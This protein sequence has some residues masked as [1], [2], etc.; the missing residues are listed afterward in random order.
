MTGTSQRT[1]QVGATF[2]PY[3]PADLNACLALFDSNCPPYFHPSEREG[4][5][6][7]LQDTADQGE[8]FV[9]EHDTEVLAC[10]G[11]WV[12]AQGVG[13]LSWGMVRGDSQGEGLHGQGLGT[14][15]TDYRLDRLRQR[16][17]VRQ[18]RLDTSQH[19]EVFY[20]RRGFVTVAR[21]PEG[22]APGID[23]IKMRL[24]LSRD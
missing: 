22:F 6:A 19:T 23:E 2:R 12:D 7:F 18:V 14:R 1:F 4:Y 3:S 24:D 20:A 9:L 15:L 10:G 11:I 17:E 16:P 13:G 8:Y 21:T 5:R